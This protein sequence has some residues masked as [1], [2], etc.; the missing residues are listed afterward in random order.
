MHSLRFAGKAFYFAGRQ[1]ACV[2]DEPP[3]VAADRPAAGYGSGGGRLS[4]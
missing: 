4:P 1:P 3:G 2:L